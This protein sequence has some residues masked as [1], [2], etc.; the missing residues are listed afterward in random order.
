MPVSTARDA[1]LEP[2]RQSTEGNKENE[3]SRP[4]T[5]AAFQLRFLCCLMFKWA[6]VIYFDHNATSPLLPE[7]REAW[8]DA[9]EKFP[10]NPSSPHRLGAR[11]DNALNEARAE[12]A[13]LLGCHDTEI[14]F[15]SGATESNNAAMHHCAASAGPHGEVWVSS[16]EHP[17]LLDPAAHFFGDRLRLIP[18][19]HAGVVELE[20]MEKSLKRT[21]PILVAVMAANNETGALQPWREVSNL[22]RAQEVPFFCDAVQWL[23]RLPADELGDCSWATGSAH[24]FGGP[25]GVGFLKVPPRTTITPLLRGGGQENARRAGTENVPGVLAM[26]AALRANLTKVKS[27]ASD[28]ALALKTAFERKLLSALPGSEIV[29][30]NSSR[31]WN[32]VSA[33][34]P[35]ADCQQ[36]WVVKLDKLG[37]AVSTGS[38]CASGKEEPSHVLRAMGYSPADAGRVLRFSASFDTAANDWNALLKALRSIHGKERPPK[39]NSVEKSAAL[40]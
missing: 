26:V 18:V 29:A 7:A 8:L 1:K 33:L 2:F 28:Q 20:W 13:E 40:D 17:C 39:E 22:C 19:S 35:E 10:G 9:C 38:A 14:V 27:G 36:R 37:F 31:L 5:P 25:R 3:T 4:A 16:I 32:T 23:G 6:H 21:R 34:M 30:Q 12:L 11:A 24:K 15:T